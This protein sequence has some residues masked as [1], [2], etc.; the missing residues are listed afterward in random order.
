MQADGK[1]MHTP[2]NMYVDDNLIAEIPSIIRQVMAASTE[3]FFI[4]TVFPELH[5]RRNAVCMEK[6][7]ADMCSYEK[8]Q[9]GIRLNTRTLVVGMM[10]V[11]LG[12]MTDE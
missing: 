4:L 5:R 1:P 2:H 8:K 12:E 3:S 7:M 9:L 6:F 11:K 10:L